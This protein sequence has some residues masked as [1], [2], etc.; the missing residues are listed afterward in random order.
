MSSKP[1]SSSLPSGTVRRGIAQDGLSVPKMV[2][3]A[4]PPTAPVPTPTTAASAP[5]APTTPSAGKK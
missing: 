2:K 1:S 5:V 4:P 3:P